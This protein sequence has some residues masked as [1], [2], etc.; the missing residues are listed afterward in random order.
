[1]A[2][3]HLK[4][5]SPTQTVQEM[6]IKTTRRYYLT[7]T[8]MATVQKITSVGKDGEILETCALPVGK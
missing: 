7:L 3:K 1:M 5:R 6:Q 2:N 8:E 4:R